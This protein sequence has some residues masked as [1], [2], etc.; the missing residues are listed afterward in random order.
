M[1]LAPN[2]D[3]RLADKAGRRMCMRAK[4]RRL[5]RAV[6]RVYPSMSD[7]L[8]APDI[9]LS[10]RDRKFAALVAH[11][12]KIDRVHASAILTRD[13]GTVAR[14]ELAVV[15]ESCGPVRAVLSDGGAA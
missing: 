12:R 7:F 10:D 5:M 14:E 6:S 8:T 4:P 3:P 11:A 15:V 2:Y 13:G 9:S 1:S